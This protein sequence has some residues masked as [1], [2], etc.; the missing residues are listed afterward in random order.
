MAEVIQT[1][2][3][4]ELPEG[5][6]TGHLKNCADRTEAVFKE[7]YPEAQGY[8]HHRLE[9]EP[10]QEWPSLKAHNLKVRKGW[11]WGFGASVVPDDFQTRQMR[12][13]L[14]QDLYFTEAIMAVA[15]VIGLLG[16]IAAVV[17]VLT[18]D[19][20]EARDLAIGA[21]SGIPVGFAAYGV[22]WLLTRPLLR[23]ATDAEAVAKEQAELAQKLREALPA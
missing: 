8:V 1:A 22:I 11:L 21:F 3:L 23:A 4:A 5:E 15:A 10:F 17:F 18:L 20:W 12:L 7:S 19:S 6:R 13:E 9:Y 14:G 16:S 2:D